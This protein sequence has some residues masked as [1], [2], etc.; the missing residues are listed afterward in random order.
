MSEFTPPAQPIGGGGASGPRADFGV[1][2]VAYLIDVVILA[3]VQFILAAILGVAGR[4]LGL[5]VTLGYLTYFEGSP[6]GQTPG[7][8]AMNIRVIDFQT[9]GELGYGK[10]LIRQIMRFVS[11]IVCLLG[12]LWMLWDK[13]KQTWHDKVAASVVVPTSAYPVAA[14]PG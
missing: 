5:L 11:G 2:F 14:W 10:A 1:R 13:E 7:K 3:V 4:G 12:Y 6:S 8:K 9:G